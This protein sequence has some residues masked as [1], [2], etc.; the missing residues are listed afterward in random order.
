MNEDNYVIPN[1]DTVVR[2]AAPYTVMRNLHMQ[3]GSPTRFPA[4]IMLACPAVQ[5]LGGTAQ[6]GDT[7]TTPRQEDRDHIWQGCLK[8][9][10][11]LAQAKVLASLVSAGC[12]CLFPPPVRDCNEA[13]VWGVLTEVFVLPTQPER[14]WVGLRPGRRSVRLEYE[15]VDLSKHGGHGTLKVV[16]NYGETA[17]SAAVIWMA[18]W[19]P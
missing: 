6:R 14:E 8:L 13:E 3:V 10:P 11:S 18:P 4:G 17:P 9:M 7:D 16:H 2:P 15:E 1:L 19:C 12:C 5:V